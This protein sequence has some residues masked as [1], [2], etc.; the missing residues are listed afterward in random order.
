MT[1]NIRRIEAIKN[2]PIAP[3][4]PMLCTMSR[5]I[6]MKKVISCPRI[7]KICDEKN[8]SRRY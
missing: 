7:E 1:E 6:L 3:H 4:S 2:L 5:A 8:V